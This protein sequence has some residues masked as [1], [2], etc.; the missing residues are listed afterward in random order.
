MLLFLDTEFTDALDCDLISIGLVS[1]D[2]QHELYLERSDY[3]AEWCNS[4][5]RAAVLPQL[6]RAGVPCEI[7]G[8]RSQ[9]AKWLGKF[10]NPV[11]V[12]C[13]SF[14]DWELLVDILGPERPSNLLGPY[15]IRKHLNQNKFNHGVAEYHAIQGPWHH[16][17]HDAK[18]LRHGWLAVG[19][20][21]H[22]T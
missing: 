3:R 9:I 19:G 8:L 14:I 15:D 22:T 12:A 17:L 7:D 13:D 2:G 4:F 11:T 10:V 20:L 21:R 1:E 18:A 6:G 5:V 16:A